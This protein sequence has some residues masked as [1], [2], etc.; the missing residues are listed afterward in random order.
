MIENSE[1]Q[2]ACVRASAAR[3]RLQNSLLA[4][5]ARISPGRLKADIQHKAIRSVVEAGQSLQTTVKAHPVA[6]GAAGVTFIAYCARRPLW[7]LFNRLFVRLHNGRNY[8]RS[9]ETKNG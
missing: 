2:D 6:A 5:K 1:Y 3:A 8:R 9:S 7:T 4:T